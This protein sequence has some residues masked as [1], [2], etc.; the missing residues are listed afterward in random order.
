MPYLGIYDVITNPNMA[1][2]VTGSGKTLAFLI[3]VLEM[4]WREK[5]SASQG[6]GALVI[7]PTRELAYQIYE[8]LKK[9]GCKHDF[10]AGLVIGGKSIDEERSRLACTNIVIATPGRLLQ[11]MDQ[12]STFSCDLLQMLVLDEADRILDMGFST[13]M[14][15]IL[16]NLPEERQTLLFSATLSNP[17]IIKL[18][19][20]SLKEGVIVSTNKTNKTPNQLSHAYVTVDLSEKLEV[21]Y[22][23]IKSHL[24]SKILVFMSSCKQV[25]FHNAVLCKLRPGV[26]ILAL[27]GKQK[28]LR[29]VGI[30]E[31]FCKK[32]SAVLLATDIAARGLDI[33]AVH[34]VVHL[35][36]AEDVETYIHRSG[37]TARYHKAGNSLAMI[38]PS[39]E[40]F[41]DNLQKHGVTLTKIRVNPQKQISIQKKVQSMCA[42]SQEVH[43]WAKKTFNSYVRS[44]FLQRDKTVFDVNKLPLSAY[45]ASLG[46][47]SAP[48]V[49]FLKKAEK[50]RGGD[51]EG[52]EQEESDKEEENEGDEGDQDDSEAEE[53]KKAFS[54]LAD[55]NDDD[56][57]LVKKDSS[58][59]DSLSTDNL[60]A[61]QPRQTKKKAKSKVA[62]AKAL[63]KKGIKVNTKISFDEEGNV[64][65]QEGAFDRQPAAALVDIT[66][67]IDPAKAG[68]IDIDEMQKD[69]RD[70][71]TE[72][73][74]TAKQRRKEAKLEK[75]E[76]RKRVRGEEA[77]VAV[78]GGCSESEEGEEEQEPE[79]KRHCSS[80]QETEDLAAHLLGDLQIYNTVIFLFVQIKYY[81]I[82]CLVLFT[83]F[84]SISLD[85][86]NTDLFVILLKGSKILSGLGE[87]SLLHTL[88]DVPVDEGSFGVHEIELVVKSGPCLSDGS[89]V[90]QH[91]HGPLDLGEVTSG[92]NGGWL[93]VDANLETSGAPVDELDG[94][95]GL[96]G[97]NGSVD[98]LGD[99]ITPVQHTTGHVLSVSGI[100][101]DHLVG[102][103]EA[104]VGDLSNGELLVVGLLSGD[105][106]SVG[107]QREVNPGVGHQVGLE[108]SQINVKGTIESQRSGDGGDD[109]SNQPVQVG[110]GRSL[111]VQVPSADIVDSLVV[112]HEGTVGVLKGGMGGQDRVV[113]LNDSGGDLGRGVDGELQLRLLSVVNTEPLAEQRGQ[114][115][116]GTSTE[117]VED[118]ESLESSTLVSLRIRE[119]LAIQYIC[120]DLFIQFHFPDSVQNKINDLLS[121]GVV[122]SGVVVS[123]ILL[124]SDQL[125]R[126]EELSVSS[127]SDLI[128]DGGLQIN[129]HSPGDVLSSSS[130]AEEG[131]EGVISTSDGLVRGHLTV[132]LD[133]VLQAVEFPAGITNLDSGLSNV[134]RDTFTH[135]EEREFRD[136]WQSGVGHQVG[137]ELSQINVKGTIE[138]QRSG[139]GGDDLSN[140]PVQVGV[141][142]SLDVQVPSADIVDGLIVDHEG[143][144]G[145]LQGGMGGQDRVVGLNDSGGDL[146][147]GVDGEL[148]LRLL[149][150]VNTEPLAEQ[151][152]QTGSGTSTEGVEDEESLESSTLVSLRIR[153][154]LAIQYICRDLFIQFHFPDSVQNKI[155]DLLSDGVVTSGVVVS[156]ILLASDQLFRVEE[157]SV[158]SSSDLIDDGGLQ[159]NKHSPGDVLSSS[160]LA[161]EGVEG[162]IST[163][164]GLVR[165]HLTV[166]LDTVLQA[167]E[168][169]A[170][171]TN[172]D[173]GLSNV[174]RDT[175][176]HDEE[177][178]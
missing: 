92:N 64:E 44:V 16:E 45:A 153:E 73:K 20:L 40:A 81:A 6:L 96:D 90:G 119:G 60:E 163:S 134:D 56:D 67:A 53:A 140:Q 13:A 42:E 138:S 103:L 79:E 100:A 172:L 31:S 101:L 108:L 178:G 99:D 157:L 162:V 72:D 70:R 27:Y 102:R 48:K 105:D 59:M 46:L 133:T 77:P 109:L 164:D 135:D 18:A 39:E 88:T 11:H 63:L 5:W 84:L 78:L 66:P 10:S 121:D 61:L 107:H 117:G 52:E 169:P 55:D 123:G 113:G 50:K 173:S 65:A 80:L 12:T 159:I 152:G 33:P 2:A 161:E 98:V 23:F 29:R 32:T 47:L 165:G 43:H 131:V 106:G 28:Q 142:R 91:A 104:S 175:F 68:G 124:A 71:D 110:V 30:Y 14:K 127:S 132:G 19:N 151:R 22:A 3:P 122:T 144:V 150:V 83:L 145:V 24:N 115:G 62:K 177:R 155:N 139:D 15:Y 94:P 17:S 93:V 74:A 26:P 41:I 141:G 87:L 7:T 116:S 118:E 166:G 85:G 130:L 112:N 160:S 111:D 86:V 176:T 149:S 76:K 148:Q 136:L 170:G 114:T 4:L 147:R 51:G 34:W 25:Q 21:L 129:K 75:K 49:R 58:V 69:M 37:R 9:I 128:D 89:G 174:D 97:G 143:T 38:L 156:G 95:L 36:C 146:G 154:G 8:V 171:I 126:V 82:N 35:D 54:A 125:F 158:S 57:I 167:V 1:E 168:F 137:L 120:R